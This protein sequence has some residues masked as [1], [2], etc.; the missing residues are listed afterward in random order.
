MSL[1]SHPVAR[2]LWCA[3][4]AAGGIALALHFVGPGMNP[5]LLASLGGSA[6]FLF[7]LTHAP[8][9][10]PRA[11]FG[12]HCIGAL[13]GIA[14]FQVFGDALWVY[15]LAQTVALMAMLISKTVHPPAGANPILM[16]HA[17][18]SWSSLMDPVI[19]GVLILA[20]VAYVWSRCYPGLCRYPCTI[21]AASPPTM[22]WGGWG[23]SVQR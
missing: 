14:C 12:G 19:F 3:C 13:A 10:Q 1:S 6:V 9:A 5:F 17:H 11:L 8:A 4:G 16:V 7:G 22:L 20:A 2:L 18:A 15:A 21:F 23:Q